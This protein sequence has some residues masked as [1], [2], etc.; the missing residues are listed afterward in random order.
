MAR[1]IYSVSRG[2]F[3]GITKKPLA[4][5]TKCYFIDEHGNRCAKGVGTFA[6]NFDNE[7]EAKEYYLEAA[8]KDVAK[9][10]Y[11]LE[12]ARKDLRKV[13]EKLAKYNKEGI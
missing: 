6:A 3:G 13:A 8:Q 2:C 5:E 11:A 1:Y 4:K 9:C 10:E 7:L 12:N